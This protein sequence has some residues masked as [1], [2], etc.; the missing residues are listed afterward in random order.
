MKRLL[1]LCLMLVS[2]VG[3]GATLPF[4]IQAAKRLAVYADAKGYTAEQIR[5]ATPEEVFTHLSIDPN[6]IQA[7]RYSALEGVIK[8]HVINSLGLQTPPT[9]QESIR[10]ALFEVF[11]SLRL[12]YNANRRLALLD[13]DGQYPDMTVSAH[14]TDPDILIIRLNGD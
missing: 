5:N 8:G 10:A 2:A 6:S 9:P 11:E 7:R 1:L 14:P 13:L 3:W 4:P 12:I